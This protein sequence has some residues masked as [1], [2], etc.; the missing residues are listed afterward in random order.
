MLTLT[1][2][3]RVRYLQ[4]NINTQ[5]YRRPKSGR[6]HFGR[7][8]ERSGVRSE[9]EEEHADTVDDEEQCNGR[10]TYLRVGGGQCDEHSG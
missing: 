1:N 2:H 5:T 3:H 6:E 9:I 4:I 10:V 7:Y 8:D